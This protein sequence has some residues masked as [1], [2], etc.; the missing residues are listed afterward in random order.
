MSLMVLHPSLSE[1]SADDPPV[2]D[3]HAIPVFSIIPS[4]KPPFP[5]FSPSERLL[6]ESPPYLAMLRR[7]NPI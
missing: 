5:P 4:P 6:N 2:P 7:K 1:P 3:A